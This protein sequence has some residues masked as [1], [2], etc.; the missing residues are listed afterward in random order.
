METKKYRIDNK[1]REGSLCSS[2]SVID[3]RL[4]PLKILKVLVEGLALNDNSGLW[5]TN[6]NGIPMVPRISPFDLVYLD[7]QNRVVQG[8][9]LLPIADFPQF[10]QPA[11][12]AL[13]LPFQ[14]VASSKTRQGD[15]LIF[16]EIE[17]AEPQSEAPA[18]EAQTAAQAVSFGE[19]EETKAEQTELLPA[20]G[21]LASFELDGSSLERQT[22]PAE[23]DEEIVSAS[24]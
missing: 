5:L 24:H 12:S 9:E 1:T 19:A 13:I 7:K 22:D 16:T 4:E 21:D 14:S 20:D 10:K 15:Q 3:A 18:E 11:V 23:L 17:E 6:M 2:V 8:L